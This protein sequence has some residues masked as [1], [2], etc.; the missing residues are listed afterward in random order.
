MIHDFWKKARYCYSFWQK[1]TVHVNLQLLS[2][3]NFKCQICDFWQT[4]DASFLTLAQLE[5]ISKQLKAIGPQVISIGG[6]E[7]LLYPDIISVVRLLSQNNF[8]V[9]ICNGWY[10]TPALAKTLFQAGIYEVSISVDYANAAKHDAQRGMPGAFAKAVAA[11]QTLN[12]NRVYPHQRVHMITVVMDDNLD[13]IEELIKLA[14]E[15]G[16]TYLLTLYSDNRGS[17]AARYTAQDTSSR[18]LSLKK[19][20]PEFV[21]LRGYIGRFSEAVQNG[22]IAPCYA[23][24]NLINISTAGNVSF[25]IDDLANHAGNIL[26]DDFSVILAKLK[27]QRQMSACKG[28]WTSCRGSIETLMYGKNKLLNLWDYYQMTKD[29]KIPARQVHAKC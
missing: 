7:P 16:V 24:I 19:K 8:P 22:G 27:Q 20:Y 23:G 25:C 21:A 12:E 15:I 11:L 28:C 13:E 29:L 18:L 1:N 6:G 14:K 5:I 4:P 3:C 10:V 17:K 9:M 26:S 2:A